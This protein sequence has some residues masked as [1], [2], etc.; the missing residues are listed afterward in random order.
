M[1]TIEII[2]W[3]VTAIIVLVMIGR[4]LDIAM[5][6]FRF[7]LRPSVWLLLRIPIFLW[8]FGALSAASS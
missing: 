1:T 2:L 8:H 7:W 6:G 3:V 5:A 4:S